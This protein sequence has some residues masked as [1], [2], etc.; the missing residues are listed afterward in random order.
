[1]KNVAIFLLCLLLTLSLTA[2]DNFRIVNKW[3]HT[4]K[5][6]G[7]LF[8][9]LIDKD[10]HIVGTFFMSGNRL[11]TPDKVI[12]IVPKKQG[13]GDVMNIRALFHYQENIAFVETAEK[14]KIFKKEGGTYKINEILWL[15]RGKLSHSIKDGVFFD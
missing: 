4:N 6:I 14:I 5:T 1:M 9:S 15:K 8:Y 3:D 11:I 2:S 10:D 7:Y 13:P 12:N